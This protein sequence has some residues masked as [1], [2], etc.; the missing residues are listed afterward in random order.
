MEAQ[1]RLQCSDATLI[2]EWFWL[3]HKPVDGCYNT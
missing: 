2:K 3:G 1:E